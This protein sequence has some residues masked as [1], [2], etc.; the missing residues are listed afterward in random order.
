VHILG[1]SDF[2]YESACCLL[3]DAQLVAAAAEMEDIFFPQKEWILDTIHERILTLPGHVPSIVQNSSEI[4]ERGF[5]R[6]ASQ[7]AALPAFPTSPLR[8]THDRFRITSLSGK[9]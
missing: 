7:R 5:C 2:Y 8:T 3:K 9:C 4:L 1:L 6:V